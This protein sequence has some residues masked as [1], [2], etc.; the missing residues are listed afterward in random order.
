M[1]RGHKSLVDLKMTRPCTAFRNTQANVT[2]KAE[3]AEG[4]G[5]QDT[6]TLSG[7]EPLSLEAALDGSPNLPT[8][9]IP[10]DSLH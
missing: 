10:I 2:R 9:S 4:A 6:I 7:P 1:I 3:G 8:K 5:H